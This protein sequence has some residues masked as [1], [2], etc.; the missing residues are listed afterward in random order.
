MMRIAG[1]IEAVCT[2]NGN[3]PSVM[4]GLQKNLKDKFQEPTDPG[5]ESLACVCAKI[6]RPHVQEVRSQER[7]H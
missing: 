4:C 3:E 5:S 6:L 1:W 7:S 2:H